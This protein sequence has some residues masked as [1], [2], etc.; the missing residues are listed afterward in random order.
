M[1]SGP[2]ENV[3]LFNVLLNALTVAFTAWLVHR[4][5]KADMRES[6]HNGRSGGDGPSKDPSRD[7]GEV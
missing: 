6:K 5:R 2:S 4:R 1:C 3:Q 7:L